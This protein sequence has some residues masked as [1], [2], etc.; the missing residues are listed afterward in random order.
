MFKK[1]TIQ[2]L[3]FISVSFS[4]CVIANDFVARASNEAAS[5]HG[6][7][8]IVTAQSSAV[9][10]S[11][12]QDFISA[13]NQLTDYVMKKFGREG[14]DS[15]KQRIFAIHAEQWNTDDPSFDPE[16]ASK[17]AL[18]ATMSSMGARAKIA[19][20][21]RTEMS[22]KDLLS[23]PPSDV[24]AELKRDY[25]E[26]ERN[27]E[28]QKRKVAKLLEQYNEHEARQ[29][30]GAGW[31]ERGKSLLDGMIKKL[32]E[33][34]DVSQLDDKIH[35]KFIHT[36]A[37]YEAATSNLILIEKKAANLKN[38][39]SSSMSSSV[40]T[41]ASGAIIGATVIATTESW[42]KEN[43][44]YQV[45]SLVVWS[46]KLKASAEAMMTGQVEQLKPKVGRT[47][48]AW[49]Q[50]Q[51]FGTLIG[52]RQLIDEH[53]NRWFI[54]AYAE[55]YSGSSAR[56]RAAKGRAEIYAKKEAAMAIF[57]DL[58]TRKNA[59]VAVQT[60]SIDLHSGRTEIAKSFG[61]MTSQS[62]EKINL[63]GGSTIM[64]REV[65]HPLTG[66]KMYSVIFAVSANAA[67]DAMK[68]EKGNYA[69]A[70]E[71]GK[72]Q[73]KRSGE[74]EGLEKALNDA[75]SNLSYFNNAKT[76]AFNEA[77]SS[78]T[79][80]K[81]NVGDIQKQEA[82]LKIQKPKIGSGTVINVEDI[83]EDDF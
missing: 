75:G 21:M 34:Y 25:E 37:E 49:L 10:V 8:A 36:K 15:S 71:I 63:S 5:D 81:E 54:G 40:N 48:S 22:A 35:Q 50:K 64:R 30:A 67:K 55:E 79:S 51:N 26:A 31:S 80:Q 57:A 7:K 12:A 70:I 43:E 73:N 46:P 16:F 72:Y 17:R 47:L 3:I 82:K 24:F 23:S 44:E 59:M 18:Y 27:F 32:D 56:K 83:D 78:V 58:E 9:E 38:S 66:T 42:D 52:P 39:V 60:R 13:E 69:A 19:E 76:E 11:E 74:K 6:N 4:Q 33:T 2:G 20:F 61:E 14:W 45:A 53:G 28:R 68:M 1:S 62:M 77:N 41:I 29:V 65:T